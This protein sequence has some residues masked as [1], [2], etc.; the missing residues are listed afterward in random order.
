MPSPRQRMRSSPETPWNSEYWFLS[1]FWSSLQLS[2][3]WILVFLVFLSPFSRTNWT[4]KWVLWWSGIYYNSQPKDYSDVEIVINWSIN[5]RNC[6]RDRKEKSQNC[7]DNMTQNIY[8]NNKICKI[9][10]GLFGSHSLILITYFYK[11]VAYRVP[12]TLRNIWTY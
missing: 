9:V 5:Q 1:S 2:K 8:Q 4:D 7:Q 10:N 11:L 12:T 6:I 3:V